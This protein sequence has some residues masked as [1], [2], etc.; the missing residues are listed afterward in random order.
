MAS[1]NYSGLKKTELIEI[2]RR[3]KAP[4]TASMNKD[5][6]IKAIKKAVK[7]KAVA[8]AK[9]VSKSKVKARPV[10][11]T[12]TKAKPSKK[13]KAAKT[14]PV[15]KAKAKAKAKAKTKVVAKAKAKTKTKIIAK[16]KTPT[17]TKTKVK[18][19]T[20][21]VS[22]STAKK[23]KSV[24]LKSA[25]PSTPAK[26]KAVS[27]KKAINKPAKKVA[28]PAVVKEAPPKPVSKKKAVSAKKTSIGKPAVKVAPLAVIKEP[29]P[30]PVSKKK[31]R[32]DWDIPIDA[33]KFFTAD[34][35]GDFS[36]EEEAQ[37]PDSYG[38]D[39]IVALPKD[40]GSLFVYWE[41]LETSSDTA[42][43]SLGKSWKQVKW[44]LRVFDVTGLPG[45]EEASHNFF[46]VTVDP[47]AGKRYLDVEGDGRE[48]IVELG[49]I[50]DDNRFSSI[51]FSNRVQTPRAGLPAGD[52]D[53][54]TEE[55]QTLYALSGGHHPGSVFMEETASMGVSS[56][57]ASEQSPSLREKQDF[58]MWVNCEV[59]VY[60]GIAPG[61]R[62][63][64]QGQEVSL[65]PDG[66]FSAKF[67]LPDG[68]QDIQVCGTSS[69]GADS[70]QISLS[71][72]RSS[73][74]VR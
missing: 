41:V 31:D 2:A 48:Y 61:S 11:K 65:R 24:I 60:G 18:A 20:G 28:R 52:D 62:L 70:K 22:G 25:R 8:K 49:L 36:P 73:R 58:S 57:G 7:S 12:G 17:V 67:H 66:A 42:L 51:C 43:R 53:F 27:A 3:K 40:P 16:V 64:L 71:V 54:I 39:R 68:V 34:E 10:K 6:I 14:A 63:V 23:K 44:T 72:S 56:F 29:P 32:N 55:A 69:D 47:E 1:I 21:K 45:V 37:L 38:E 30:K 26:K 35:Q 4:V 13:A 15:K 59:T 74:I 19:K 5:E 50:D 46:D 9:P 33:G